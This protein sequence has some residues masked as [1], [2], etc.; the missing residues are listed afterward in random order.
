MNEVL[1]AMAERY[2][3]RDFADTPLTDQQVEAIANAAMQAPSAVN[4]QPWRVTIVTDK[5]LIG[6][7]EA[8][9]MNVLANAE[10]KSGYERIMSRGG[11]VYYNAPCVVVVT[12]DGSSWAG[13]DSG[14]L[15]QNIAL[16]AHS[17][18]LGSVINGMMNM[19]LSGPRGGEL[20]KRLQFED[21]FEFTIAALIGT[22]KSSRAPHEPDMG[23]VTYIA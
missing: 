17:L 10:D 8:E 23:K 4:R 19:P 2:S 5:K 18:G 11:K 9:A 22:A 20:K 6:E 1:K 3:C 16:A 12:S 14:I 13:I 15:I 7:L 21:G